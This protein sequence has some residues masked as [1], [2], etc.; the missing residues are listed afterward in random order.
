M[1]LVKFL[2]ENPGYLK[3]GKGY[4]ASKFS[5][6]YNEVNKAFK[7]AKT[8]ING[9]IPQQ[10]IKPAKIASDNFL[11]SESEYRDF[12]RWK[13]AQ[14]I[15]AD[16][17]IK[18]KAPKKLPSPFLTGDKRNVLVIGDTHEPFCR[19]GYL[20]FCR[21]VQERYNCGTVIH[22]GDCVDNHAISY[23]E[24]D[25]DGRSAG[26]E[27]AEALEKM[28][29]WYQVFPKVKVCIGNH[30]ALPYRKVFTAGLP[31][32]W[33]KSHKEI[34][35]APEGWEWDFTH[36]IQDVIYTH[37]TGL[38]GDQAAINTARENRQSTVIGHLHSISNVK[39]MASYKDLIFGMTVGC[40]IDDSQYAFSYG[41]NNP[42]KSV[43]SCGVVLQG[44][45]P[46]IVPMVL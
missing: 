1:N 2:I 34:L 7:E 44:K 14:M 43:L 21:E 9:N 6:P 35:N 25:P 8:I 10:D 17:Q 41:K 38:S 45:E 16:E 11:S 27:N 18:R 5:V 3:K 24:S 30:D 15:P 31:M 36:I 29:N 13:R 23:H 40:G 4:I 19:E 12:L 28:K 37:G 39:F 46:I 20:E 33:L 42:R 32:S 26:D 22:I